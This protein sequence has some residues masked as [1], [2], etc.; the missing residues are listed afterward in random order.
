MKRTDDDN[1]APLSAVMGPG[2]HYEG[3][4]SFE[5]RVR[6]DGHFT[7]R[8]YSEDLLELGVQ[9]TIEGEADVARA[10]IAGRVIGRLRV[11]ERLVVDSTGSIEGTGARTSGE[12]LIRGEEVP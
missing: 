1:D 4:L 3:D 11:R 7:G 5:G 12:V 6:V 10:I 9:G 2:A 8:I